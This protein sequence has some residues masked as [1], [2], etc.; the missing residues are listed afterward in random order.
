MVAAHESRVEAGLAVLGA[1]LGRGRRPNTAERGKAALEERRAMERREHR[2][3]IDAPDREL[4]AKRGGE[5]DG[6]V[7]RGAVE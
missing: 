7:L 4:H 6:G 1:H 5:G 2:T 3:D